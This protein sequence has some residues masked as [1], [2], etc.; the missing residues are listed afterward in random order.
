MVVPGM[1]GDGYATA[2]L[3]DPLPFQVTDLVFPKR[4]LFSPNGR[5]TNRLHL[6]HVFKKR[7][8]CGAVEHVFKKRRPCGAVEHVFKM[9]RTMRGVLGRWCGPDC[10]V[11]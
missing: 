7:R 8:P 10:G 1:E 5:F 2:G 3:T 11:W 4:I 9:R 6:E